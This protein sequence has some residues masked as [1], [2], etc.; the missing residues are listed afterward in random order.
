MANN[1]NNENKQRIA[2]LQAKEGN[3]QLTDEEAAELQRLQNETSADESTS[4]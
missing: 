1:K 4:K 3:G 2:E